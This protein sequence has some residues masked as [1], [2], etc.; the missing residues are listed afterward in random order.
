MNIWIWICHMGSQLSQNESKCI[1]MY[2]NVYVNVY[3]YVCKCIFPLSTHWLDLNLSRSKYQAVPIHKGNKD[4]NAF[5]LLGLGK[6]QADIGHGTANQWPWH[7]YSTVL[8]GWSGK[9]W[10]R[11][12]IS[13]QPL[14]KGWNRSRDSQLSI[15]EC[16]SS[17]EWNRG[18]AFL[19]S[20]KVG[21][22]S[23]R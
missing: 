16:I 14:V 3:V 17:L 7:K 4:L 23:V 6:V 13:Q 20:S 18:T 5:I 8:L 15:N 9:G 1:C 22:N 21:I 11:S 12:R 2:V 19:L 10:N